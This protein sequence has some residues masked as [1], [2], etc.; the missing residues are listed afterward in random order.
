MVYLIKTS[1]TSSV[2][3]VYA[4]SPITFITGE[5]KQHKGVWGHRRSMALCYDSLWLMASTTRLH[6]TIMTVISEIA[7]ARR[8]LIWEM[9]ITQ[10]WFKTGRAVHCFGHRVA[11]PL[12]PFRYSAASRMFATLADDT[13]FPV[14]QNQTILALGG[15][16]HVCPRLIKP[17]DYGQSFR[18]YLQARNY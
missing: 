14:S 15:S 10:L 5:P 13:V 4:S 9:Y 11:L 8:S 18:W 1:L 2:Q 6:F 12:L 17:V 16:A 7:P 3:D